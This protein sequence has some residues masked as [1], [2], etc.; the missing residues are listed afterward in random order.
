MAEVVRQ[1]Q[2]R[3][4]GNPKR[5]AFLADDDLTHG[6]VAAAA[7]L[8]QNAIE[9]AP[10]YKQSYL[11][12]G[13]LKLASGE[14]TAAAR[15]FHSYPGLRP[16]SSTDRVSIAFTASQMG[17]YFFTAG[18]FDLAIPFFRIATSQDSGAASEMSADMRLKLLAG[19]IDGALLSSLERAQRYHDSKAYRDYLSMLHAT[20]HSQDAWAGFRTL[21]AE[22][23]DSPVWDSA[24][25]GHRMAGST[26]AQVV[27][28]AKQ[29]DF[30]GNHVGQASAYL[31]RFATTDRL[32]SEGLQSVIADL[33]RTTWQFDVGARS[34]VR[35]D[36][37]GR[38][39]KILGP[40]GAITP[41]GILPIGAFDNGGPK[42]QVRS[43]LSFFVQA[44]RAI[45]LQ[46]YQGA[47][48]VFD[49]AAVLY[50]MA[51][52][53]SSY[54]LPYYALASVKAGA[55]VSAVEK[56]LDRI[57]PKEQLFDYQLARAVLEALHGKMPDA[58]VS[59]KLARYRRT[60]IEDGVQQSQF[61]YG[62]VCE[63]LYQLTGNPEIR[64]FALDW[65]RS[66]EKAE[67]WQS[68]SYALEA[69]LTSNPE[70][71]QKAIAM[72]FYLDPNSPH[73][74]S[75]KKSDI[76]D[77]VK[78]FGPANIFLKKKSGAVKGGMTS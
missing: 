38:T 46:D 37:D 19:D 8:L 40:V 6:N 42:H 2:G 48:G 11:D 7:V 3:F 57:K 25:V 56:T 32:P 34:V 22:L 53:Q 23:D 52:N 41:Q 43:E 65:A 28:W 51:S 30:A 12:L 31:A 76:D 21:V 61:T 16:D 9:L 75:F 10:A 49:E 68:W 27:E 39:Q 44:Y 47:K 14:P 18:D 72:T 67:P 55:D 63:S 74:S 73:L 45:K 5:E 60:G 70:E 58:L 59:L 77:A 35:P 20:K 4:I 13:K 17:T 78:L 64:R 50:D 33:D 62:D 29:S 69:T 24:L 36:A 1:I 54:M 15:I 26:E 71:R 66:R